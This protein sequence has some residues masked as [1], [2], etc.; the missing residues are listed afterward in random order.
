MK[1]TL[2]YH[3]KQ[4]EQQQAQAEEAVHQMMKWTDH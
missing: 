2:K 1:M 3:N 4:Q